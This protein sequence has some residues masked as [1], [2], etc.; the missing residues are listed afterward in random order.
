MDNT[1]TNNKDKKDKKDKKDFP[2]LLNVF[3]KFISLLFAILPVFFILL[4]YSLFF[5]FIP[6]ESGKSG[7]KEETMKIEQTAEN[8]TG[9]DENS[10]IVAVDDQYFVEFV[11]GNGETWRGGL[12]N[13]YVTLPDHPRLKVTCFDSEF[14]PEYQN[15]SIIL[16]GNR[17][18]SLSEAY[19]MQYD[20]ETKTLVVFLWRDEPYRLEKD[21]LEKIE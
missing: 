13:P 11:Y 9:A 15:G 18:F 16:P 3:Q 20:Q 2:T 8:I 14:D 19:D 10:T 7:S 1:N 4:I 6:M 17:P 12:M 21:I 5:G